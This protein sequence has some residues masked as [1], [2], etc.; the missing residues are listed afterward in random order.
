MG[1]DMAT[2]A[3][4]TMTTMMMTRTGET[5]TAKLLVR[6]LLLAALGMS[7]LGG[8]AGA[9]APPANTEAPLRALVHS[10]RDPDLRWPAFPEFRSELGRLYQR[11]AWQPLWLRD[12]RPT[13][14]A[15]QLIARLAAADTL[16]LEPGDYD[17]MWLGREA[18]A[19]V[20]PGHT[21][22]PGGLARFDLGLSV[23]AVRFVS[24]LHRGRVSPRVVHAELFI[25]RSF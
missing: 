15:T 10:A 18:S 11:A 24:A 19:L 2:A 7:M 13:E 12:A 20:A 8:I 21:P 17:A 9:T 16:G 4:D 1:M 5:V 22:S 25:P 6:A 3:T 14:A 23:A